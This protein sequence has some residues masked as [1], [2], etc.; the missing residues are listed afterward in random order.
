[1]SE[2]PAEVMDLICSHCDSHALAKLSLVSRSFQSHT[3]K[4]LF[5]QVALKSS[6]STKLLVR[7]LLANKELEKM[8]SALVM[9]RG[10]EK[11]SAEKQPQ[12]SPTSSPLARG[13]RNKRAPVPIKQKDD[14][15]REEDLLSLVRISHFS[16]LDPRFPNLESLS[17]LG[18]FDLQRRHL[19]FTVFCPNLT[20]LS[21]FGGSGK[22]ASPTR[23]KRRG[24]DGGRFSLDAVG[25]IVAALPLLKHLALRRIAVYPTSL[26]GIPMPQQL[27]LASFALFDTPGL[28]PRQLRW[29][30]RST[31]HAETLRTLA[32]NWDESARI[33]N[34]V[35]Y[36]VLRLETLFLT[37][38]TSGV[39]ESLVP[40]CAS[41]KH[42]HFQS[43]APVDLFRL[44]SHFD[45]SLLTITDRSPSSG[46]GTLSDIVSIVLDSTKKSSRELRLVQFRGL[47]STSLA[48]TDERKTIRFETVNDL[49][50]EDFPYIP[51]M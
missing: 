40:H 49:R 39:V 24:G 9:E 13:K 32:M 20:S 45:T 23:P 4:R 5:T 31:S 15:A 44:F 33:L 26:S 8:T 19:T 2:L 42:L 22:E 51:E 16:D 35:R 27:Q 43:S 1:M 25:R 41:L 30:L 7:S 11:Q 47:P 28:H 34:P 18:S 12:L 14:R 21:I 3:T 48:T 37:T 38:S 29:L 10:S 50:S 6:T 17:L 46:R 36:V